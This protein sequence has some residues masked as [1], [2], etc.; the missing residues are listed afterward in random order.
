[1]GSVAAPQ[2]SHKSRGYN[3]PIEI[4]VFSQ[5][6]RSLP[7]DCACLTAKCAPIHPRKWHS[8]VFARLQA[9][10]ASNESGG[11]FHT[12]NSSAECLRQSKRCSVRY[13]SV[14]AMQKLA[15]IGPLAAA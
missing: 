8:A 3:M 13:D 12:A 2:R 14:N 15:A 7:S 10:V 6:A 1:M 9:Q 11:D 5:T 4:R